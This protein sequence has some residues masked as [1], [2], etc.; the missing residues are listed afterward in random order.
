MD[1][2][3]INA[4]E[5]QVT[6]DNAIDGMNHNLDRIENG[7]NSIAW[8][9]FLTDVKTLDSI[10]KYVDE[11]YQKYFEV[12]GIN[13]ILSKPTLVNTAKFGHILKDISKG[14]VE[15]VSALY[16]GYSSK[17]D[18][19]L[20]RTKKLRNDAELLKVTSMPMRVFNRAEV[21][22]ASCIM[23]G[24]EDGCYYP[25]YG[26]GRVLLTAFK[27]NI[28]SISLEKCVM[29]FNFE[30]NSFDLYEAFVK[31]EIMFICNYDYKAYY[32]LYNPNDRSWG[33]YQEVK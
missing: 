5:L 21:K 31:C 26:T 17:F 16:S 30:V 2:S 24:N 7:L 32:I 22:C 27:Y 14:D 19:L 28:P 10:N 18:K 25:S 6:F 9:D 23:L 29:E 20:E 3:K 11:F 13:G 1:L 12:L 4:I 8:V 15:L 33:C